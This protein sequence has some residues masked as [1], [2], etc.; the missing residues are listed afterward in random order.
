MSKLN[1]SD[2]LPKL[3]QVLLSAGLLAFLVNQL[4]Q[5]N[6]PLWVEASA[7]KNGIVHFG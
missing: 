4:P 6:L 7:Y 3:L 5:I 2:L 1:I